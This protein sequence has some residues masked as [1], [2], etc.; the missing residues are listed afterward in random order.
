MTGSAP[1]QD[2]GLPSTPE[3]FGQDSPRFDSNGPSANLQVVLYGSSSSIKYDF[4][5]ELFRKATVGADIDKF[6]E[7][8]R[9]QILDRTGDAASTPRSECTP[10]RPSLA[11]VYH[12]YA[13][14][15]IPQHTAY[16][17][18]II[19]TNNDLF[20][21]EFQEARE[22]W[23]SYNIPTHRILRLEASSSSMLF[24]AEDVH[25][26]DPYHTHQAI[27]RIMKQEK[28]V[29][30]FGMFEQFNTVHA[31]T[32]FALLCLITGF[33]VN[34]ALSAQ[35]LKGFTI[36]SPSPTIA[37]KSNSNQS[38]A[39]AVRT[40]SS[41]SVIPAAINYAPARGAVL[42]TAASSPSTQSG[43]R[44]VGP[45]THVEDTL[46][47][48]WTERLKVSKEIMVRPSTSV[49]AQTSSVVSSA[50]ATTSPASSA[51]TLRLVDSLSEIVA[52][53]FKSLIDAVEHDLKDLIL[54]LDELAQAIKRSTRAVTEQSKSA[55][56]V[57][58]EQFEYR[59]A[60]AK[61][62][63]RE[64]REKG[65]QMISDAGSSFWGRTNKAKERASFIKDLVVSSDAWNSY[66]KSHGEWRD[67]LRARARHARHRARHQKDGMK[68]RS[69]V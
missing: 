51:V 40:T 59:N 26:L 31:V 16:L 56:Q 44:D 32:L 43:S 42:P 18:V 46:P 8:V 4:A 14:A 62:K 9:P 66:V 7:T 20:E 65:M 68:S 55:A 64:I 54:A 19:P 50:V 5:E 15:T 12:P 35:P 69:S 45:I 47:M 61:G 6:A 58:R 29:S 38:T 21:K 25:K 39:L 1:I 23:A 27:Q 49:S 2:P 28:T 52:A 13:N 67:E 53:S 36:I 33:S 24:A 3:V 57:I 30:W 34:T 11:I 60:R 48:T 63:A 17:P 37:G 22:A 41:I 10:D